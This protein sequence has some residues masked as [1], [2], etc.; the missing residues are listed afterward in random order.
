MSRG[1]PK[2][3]KNSKQK[4][5]VVKIDRATLEKIYELAQDGHGV[6]FCDNSGQAIIV[7]K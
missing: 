2:G 5:V 3:S 1:R 6:Y 4:S 7:S